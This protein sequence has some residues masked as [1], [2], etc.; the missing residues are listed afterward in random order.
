MECRNKFKSYERFAEIIS[1]KNITPYRVAMDTG[2]SPMTLS[3]WKNGKSKPK[4]DKL[5]KIATYLEIDVTQ[6][7]DSE[8]E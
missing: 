1:M 3:D 7:S 2:I 4:F 5:L 6:F 8:V